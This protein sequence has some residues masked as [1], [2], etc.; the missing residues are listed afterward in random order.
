LLP[1]ISI[2]TPTKNQAEFLEQTIESIL[3][4]NYPNLEFLILDGGSRDG[5]IEILRKYEKF[6][7]W[8]SENNKGQVDAINKG[9]KTVKGEVVA[10]INSDDWIFPGTL[11][12]IG[13]FFLENPKVK[14]VTGKCLNV[15]TNRKPIRSFITLY[16]NFL[17]RHQKPGLLKICNYIS[18]PATFWKKELH[19]SIGFFNPDYQY[20]MDYDFWL[21]VN[22]I[23][24]IHFIETYFAN[25]RVYPTSIT[26]SNSRAQFI[27]E[28]QI[29]GKY[30][31]NVLK[32]LHKLHSS[33][34]YLVYL[35]LNRNN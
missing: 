30:S 12:R 23:E 22:Q 7:F 13:E 16:K 26:S 34:A 25:F 15:D 17:L 33:F 1:S 32:L 28:Y 29:A 9:L 11:L 18:Q 21:R 14:I 3:A 19:D 8:R 27:E 10:Y 35:Y 20:A 4:Q 5:T 24:K 2:I 6:L 31:N